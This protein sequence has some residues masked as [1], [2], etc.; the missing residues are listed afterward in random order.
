MPSLGEELKRLRA[1]KGWSL[2]QVE[3]RTKENVSNSYLSQL[4]NGSVKEPSPNVLFELAKV[5]G[6]PYPALMELAGYVVPNAKNK[7]TSNGSIAFNALDLSPDE[8]RMVLDF[9]QFQRQQKQK[10]Q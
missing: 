1:L 8:E 10:K 9:I 4:E 3:E 7:G 2:R 6:V 5:Y